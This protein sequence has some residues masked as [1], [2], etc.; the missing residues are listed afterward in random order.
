M[1]APIQGDAVRHKELSPLKSKIMGRLLQLSIIFAV[2]C[3]AVS[4]D[5]FAIVGKQSYAPTVIAI[6]AAWLLTWILSKLIDLW[7]AMQRSP[8]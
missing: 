7:R 2:M 4:Y 1:H 8:Q 5:W 3:V 6:F